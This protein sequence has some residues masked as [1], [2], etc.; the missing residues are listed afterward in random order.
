M[1]AIRWLPEVVDLLAILRRDPN[2]IRG[3]KAARRVRN[4]AEG[5]WSPFA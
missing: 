3:M 4:Y 2:V 5:G 1:M